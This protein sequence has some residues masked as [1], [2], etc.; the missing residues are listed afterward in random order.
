MRQKVPERRDIRLSGDYKKPTKEDIVKAIPEMS[1]D[2]YLV[3]FTERTGYHERWGGDRDDADIP[4]QYYCFVVEKM[5]DE[6]DEE[7]LKR[8]NKDEKA[9]QELEERDKIQY[10]RLKAKFEPQ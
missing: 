6:T 1:E 5:R 2:E 4:Y 8:M 7:F 10:L 3:G 9:K